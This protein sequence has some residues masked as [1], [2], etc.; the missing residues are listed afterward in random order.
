MMRFRRWIA[1]S[2][3]GA[4]LMAD[5]AYALLSIGVFLV[6]ALGVRGLERW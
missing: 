1:W 4:T 2:R 3:R 6:L 5:V